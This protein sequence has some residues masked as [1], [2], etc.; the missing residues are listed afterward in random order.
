[1]SYLDAD[2]TM[3]IVDLKFSLWLINLGEIALQASLKVRP[4][5]PD[6]VRALH[7]KTGAFHPN[8]E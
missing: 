3:L 5:M 8:L 1:M 4:P 6:H 2:V 7:R